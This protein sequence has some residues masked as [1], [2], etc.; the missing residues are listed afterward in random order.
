MLLSGRALKRK[1]KLAEW[2][3]RLEL[4]HKKYPRLGEIAKLFG[5]ISLELAMLEVGKGKMG[6]SR[7]ELLKSLENLQ[8]EKDILLRKFNLPKNIY[9]IWWDCEKCQDTGFIGVGKKC[10]CLIQ[11]E[12]QGRWNFS[13]LAPEQ[14]D[15]TFNNFSLDWYDDKEKYRSILQ[16]SI[17]FAEKVCSGERTENLFICGPIGTGKTHLC[18]AIA[19]FVLQTGI[20]VVYLKTGKIMDM[21][22]EYK[23]NP[24]KAE[25]SLNNELKSFYRVNL[26]II[27]DLGTEVSTDFV[28][29]QLFYLL[30]ER[31]NYRLPWVIST[32]LMPNEIGTIYEDR[33]SDRILGTSRVLKFTGRSIRQLKAVSLQQNT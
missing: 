21:I 18:S 30:D 6:M 32:N 11:E 28:R 33:L 25:I 9:D 1:K 13:G 17:G 24:D 8:A 26:L 3:A 15:Q 20:N 14:K 4:L 31:I 2:E 12:M 23:L 27:D 16:Y 5:Q 19:N 7:E 29:E 22:R 10:T